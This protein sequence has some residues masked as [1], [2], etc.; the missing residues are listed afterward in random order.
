MFTVFHRKIIPEKKITCENIQYYDLIKNIRN[1][2]TLTKNEFEYISGLPSENLVEIITIYDTLV[3][4]YRD[5][6]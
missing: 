1:S 4:L 6:L 3:K 5:E 2:I